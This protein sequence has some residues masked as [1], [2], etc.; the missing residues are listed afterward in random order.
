MTITAELCL[1][2]E[3]C[4]GLSRY[5]RARHIRPQRSHPVPPSS[6]PSSLMNS[7]EAAV[8]KFLPKS[9]LSRVIIRDNLNAQRLYEMEVK[10]SQAFVL[11][12]GVSGLTHIY[13]TLTD[14]LGEIADLRGGR[15]PLW[16]SNTSSIFQRTLRLWITD[17][18]R[19]SQLFCAERAWEK[20]FMFWL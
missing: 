20:G 6:A 15:E 18:P 11:L 4:G 12:E 17:L 5:S 13:F 7:S 19:V 16:C 9:H 3:T 10:S 1:S 2:P 8:T 14:T